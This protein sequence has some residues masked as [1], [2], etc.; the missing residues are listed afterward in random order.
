MFLTNLKLE[1]GGYFCGHHWKLQKGN[2][3]SIFNICITNKFEYFCS[4]KFFI[5]G[6]IEQM[7]SRADKLSV[8]LAA[9][10]D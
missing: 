3:G 6:E 1:G 8:C 10:L 2:C 9:C 4:P 7:T 5:L